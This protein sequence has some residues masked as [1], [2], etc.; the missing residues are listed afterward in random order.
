MPK[1]KIKTQNL[2]ANEAAFLERQLASVKTKTYDRLF[3]EYAAERLIPVSTEA[4]SGAETIV[5]QTYTPA[6]MAKIISDYS[7]DLP[8]VDVAAEEKSVIVRSIADAYAYSLQEVRAAAFAAQTGKPNAAKLRQRKADAAKQGITAKINSL[9]WKAHPDKDN[10]LTGLFYQP[11]ITVSIAPTNAAGTSTKWADKTPDEILADMNGIVNG[12]FDLTNGVERPDT[13]LIPNEQYAYI[14]S[15]PRSNNSDTTILD[16][17]LN[18]NPFIN[19]VEPLFECKNVN[20]RPS[21]TTGSANIMVVYKK[22]R[23][24]LT[25]EIPQP[26]EQLAVQ[27]KNLEFQVP[28]HAR[29][30]ATIVYYPLSVAIYE[31]I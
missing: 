5:Y 31:G 16:Y 14:A 3:P 4:G 26:F 27:P 13:M 6:G 11:N 18:N 15:T 21:G 20:P 10:G 24:K 28:C 7:D 1:D 19:S 12:V 8:R 9:A 23:N 22:D 25:L 2:D 30:A 17:F 29:T